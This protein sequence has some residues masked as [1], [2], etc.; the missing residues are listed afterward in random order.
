MLDALKTDSGKRPAFIRVPAWIVSSGVWRDWPCQDVKVLLVLCAHLDRKNHC[1]P[2]MRRMGGALGWTRKHISESVQRLWRDGVI[3]VTRRKRQ[4]QFYEVAMDA[5][6]CIEFAASYHRLMS[7]RRLHQ[8][9]RVFSVNSYRSKTLREKSLML[10]QRLHRTRSI[11]EN[12]REPDFSQQHPLQPV[13]NH[14]IQ[15]IIHVN[16]IDTV[17]TQVVERSNQE[18][19]P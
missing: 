16:P 10:P 1:Y 13:V 2:S 14:I 9:K 11:K 15:N 8:E 5:T 17:K 19:L 7:P 4:S 3:R 12:K 6:S 18:I